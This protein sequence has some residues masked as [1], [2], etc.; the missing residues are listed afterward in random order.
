MYLQRGTLTLSR[1]SDMFHARQ[2]VDT[3][4][5]ATFKENAL[6]GIRFQKVDT[7]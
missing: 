6:R 2:L 4:I 7:D 5:C 1:H 3:K